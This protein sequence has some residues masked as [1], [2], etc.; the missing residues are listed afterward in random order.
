MASDS[1]SRLDRSARRNRGSLLAPMALLALLAAFAFQA[2]ATESTTGPE[3]GV[4]VLEFP[5]YNTEYRGLVTDL[6]PIDRGAVKVELSSPE[7]ELTVL[8][9][10][11]SLWP[12]VEGLH[13]ARFEATFSGHGELVAKVHVGSIPAN[14]DDRVTI[15][16][17]TKIVDAVVRIAPDPEGYM[18]TAE[19]LPSHFQVTIESELASSL[20][21]LCGGFSFFL[22]SR[23]A[24]DGLETLLQNPRMS[25]PPPGTDFLVHRDY[26]TDA[27]RARI[28]AFLGL[29]AVAA[30][31]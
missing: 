25:M 12:G 27:E 30:A 29:P 21:S 22:G 11:F 16:E 17:Q 20:V 15:P 13:D 24:C 4:L 3:D 8:G 18:V 10:R 9:H 5:R 31:R 7:H 1:H 19:E 23:A 14:L 6:E 26:F 2:P 28:D